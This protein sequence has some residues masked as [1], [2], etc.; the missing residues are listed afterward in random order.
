MWIRRSAAAL[1]ALAGVGMLTPQS[2]HAINENPCPVAR[3]LAL[4]GLQLYDLKPEPGLEAL[5]RAYKLCP[6]DLAITYNTGLANFSSGNI[7]RAR[8]LWKLSSS[9]HPEHRPS[10]ANLA[11]TYFELGEDES[12]H[13][14][15]FKALARFPGDIPLAHTKIYSLF[16]MGRY[17]E[18]YDWLVRAKLEGLRAAKW[19]REATEYV[20]EN[21]WRRF[22]R[23]DEYDA[24]RRTVNLLVKE[25]PKEE[26]FIV[27]KDMLARAMVNP[28]AEAP[29]AIPMPHEAWAKR[30]N[31]DD[32]REIL[33][34][35][36]AALPGLNVWEKRQDAYAV[37][38]GVSRYKEL[39]GRPYGARDAKLFAD[40]LSKR[41]VLLGDDAHLRLRTDAEATQGV[42]AQDM[43]WLLEQ[44]RLNPNAQLIFY[45]SGHGARTVAMGQ[46]QTLALLVDAPSSG[47]FS[48]TG[49]SL[50]NF[51]DLLE[52]LVNRDVLVVVDACFSGQ[53]PCV[54][55]SEDAS[56]G[57]LF[58]STKPWIWAAA[59]GG[60]AAD[61]VPGRQSAL[62]YFL[63]KGMLGAGDGAAGRE[64]DGWTQLD[65]A[66]AYAKQAIAKHDL[67]MQP[68]ASNLTPLRLTK[69]GGER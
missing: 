27:A 56:S 53:A 11:W 54:A 49:L 48:R 41:G 6:D 65:E 55:A 59:D 52:K 19:K 25:Y 20:V 17:L 47:D 33:D 16:R 44:G 26:A 34:E 37:V 69:S 31:V 4:K 57:P 45:F 67:S 38:V 35:F 24:L 9:A 40:L 3:E 22:R 66:F 15:A 64:A 39:P 14:T 21:L 1:A 36:I 28:D 5:E 58:S 13:I 2:A 30:G 32:R 62:S 61:Y 51:N 23:G 50:N 68:G 7:E 18:A 42:V 63:A 12:A 29:F 60:S 46:S 10:V 8:D 43:M